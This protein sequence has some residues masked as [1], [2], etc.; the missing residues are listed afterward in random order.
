M[1][2]RF[3]GNPPSKPGTPTLSQQLQT[4][5]RQAFALHQQGRLEAAQTLYREI[6]KVQPR[7]FDALHLSGVLAIQ[8]GKPALGLR[9]IDQAIQ[10]NP[11]VAAAHVHRGNA[12]KRLN[13][14]DEA[15]ASYDQAVTRQPDYAD[16]WYNRGNL[17]RQVGQLEEAVASYDR[18]LALQ[19]QRADAWNNHGNTLMALRRPAE[20]LDSFDRART[21]DPKLADAWNNRG[22]ALL[23]LDQTAAALASYDQALALQPQ[24]AD[25]WQNR[26]NALLALR[27]INEALASYDQA[28]AVD[29]DNAD[30]WYN[31]GIALLALPQ[32][33]TA[34]TSFNQALRLKPDFAAAHHNQGVALAQL[35]R[36]EAALASFDRALRIKP[37]LGDAH[38][39]RGNVLK[40]LQ[41]HDE[42]LLS[43]RRA[44]ELTPDAPLL[45]GS[46][47]HSKMQL[48]D[49][50]EFADNVATYEADITTGRRLTE[51]FIC[52]ALLDRPEL[53]QIAARRY[54]EARYPRNQAL[55]PFSAR[56]AGA[57]LRVGYY[58]ADFRQHPVAFLMAGLFEVHDRRD[59]E[60]YGFAL[61][62]ACADA[63]RQRLS[64]AFDNFLEVG[65]LSDEDIAKR[66]RALGIDIAVNL[67]GYT[68][69][70]RM[71][72]FAAGCAPI[73][74][75]YLGY[76]GT[77]GADYLDY[78]IADQTLLPPESQSYFTERVVYLPH[79]FQVNDPTRPIADRTPTRAEAGLPEQGFVYCCFNNGYKILPTT[80]DGWMRILH[81]QEA[82]VLWLLADHPLVA[83]HLRRAA[84]AR[85]IDG[86]RLIFAQ[87]L[88]QAEYLARYRMA[89]LYL[90]TLPY[91][92]GTMANDVLWAGL[93]LLTLR[94]QSFAGRMAASLLNA[95]GLPELVTATQ[96]DY[97]ALAIALAREPERLTAIR[98][99]LAENRLSWPLFDLTRFAR[100]LESAYRAMQARHLVG[101]AP[102]VITIP[103]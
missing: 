24:R 88:P 54:T 81:Q 18:T 75:S 103:P 59:C 101:L 40:D 83:H 52:L 66:S 62:P 99:R 72:A 35:G 44:L 102:G 2:A 21:L 69:H 25:A 3:H 87:R 77:L 19:P 56:A 26:G 10:I 31:R 50:E 93:P 57:K 7:H 9:L 73:Q 12:L 65:H 23:D 32:P 55:G 38:Y 63:M 49:W 20:A 22:N 46:Y 45:F 71:G 47:L 86:Q 79:S 78:V 67:G 39:S 70:H 89:D 91:N 16:A 33:E 4:K 30:G 96:Q 53:Q 43:Y 97:E 64:R 68:Q 61:G 76:P 17:L 90:D 15:L 60:W 8:A 5:L 42:A 37:D 82:A 29:R 14:L 94:G 51:P 36:L 80:F 84:E 98:R 41:R 85:G 58:S 48:C 74:V 28:L 27:R 100:H 11:T 1:V 34:L 6:L 95:I 92:A 13:R